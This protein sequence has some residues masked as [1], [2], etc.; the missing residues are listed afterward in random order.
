[1]KEVIMS[2]GDTQAKRIRGGGGEERERGKREEMRGEQS[3]KVAILR[4][5]IVWKSAILKRESV[6]A[7]CE[8]VRI[9]PFKKG[10]RM[11]EWYHV[12]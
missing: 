10:K 5:K 2:A 1:M 6:R 12:K 3:D 4:G 9:V 8:S 7:G 11:R